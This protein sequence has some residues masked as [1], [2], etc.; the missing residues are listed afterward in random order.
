M[1][2]TLTATLC[3][4]LGFAATAAISASVYEPDSH[5]DGGFEGPEVDRDDPTVDPVD[6]GP[7]DQ[8]GEDDGTGNDG[9]GDVDTGD[10]GT[11]NDGRE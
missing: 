2:T 3:I 4:L 6:P 9:R 8:D 10:D 5:G 1:K 11:E 7:T